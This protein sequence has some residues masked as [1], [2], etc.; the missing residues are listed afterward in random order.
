MN[1][2]TLFFLLFLLNL[3]MV[4]AQDG[5]YDPSFGNNGVVYTDIDQQVEVFNAVAQSPSGKIAVA[6]E[7]LGET[8]VISFIVMYLEDGTI[9]L[10]FAD[11]GFLIDPITLEYKNIVF[12]SNGKL[13]AVY[14]GSGQTIIR[15][16]PD[17]SLDTAFGTNGS[18][19]VDGR[20]LQLDE[21]DQIYVQENQNNSV[22]LKRLL[23]NGDLDTA[24]GT[25]GLLTI[26]PNN[27]GSVSGIKVTLLPSGNLFLNY[28]ETAGGNAPSY[29]EK[30]HSNGELD[31]TFG[32]NGKIE[33]PIEEEFACSTRAFSDES[34][35]VSCSYWDFDLMM[36][37][38]KLLKLSPE[39]NFDA[40]FGTNGYIQGRSVEL[41]QQNQRFITNSS[42]VDYEGGTNINFKRYYSNGTLDSSFQFE[43][44]PETIE[45]TYKSMITNSGKL[46]VAANNM[47]LDPFQDI[48]LFQ[49]HNDPLGIPEEIKTRITV[50]PN[51]SNGVFYLKRQHAIHNSY[52]VS[53]I[54]GRVLLAGTFRNTENQVDL[55]SFAAGMYFLKCAGNTFRLLK[56]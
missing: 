41:I 10:S 39:G 14:G 47:G 11:N 31:T 44:A 27:G 6:G 40:N 21:N 18:I 28:D 16:L 56:N 34:V 19:Y 22:I 45:H 12:Q 46:L 49:Y 24:Y 42:S 53:D 30:Y 7:S 50:L 9:D 8:D 25:N 23:P 37:V 29:I 3:G 35:L 26:T 48:L 32:T 17:G 36:M 38:Y 15:L 52:T 5:S 4:I 13:I 55:S 43:P 33:I 1:K 54:N 2:I 20:F 51:P